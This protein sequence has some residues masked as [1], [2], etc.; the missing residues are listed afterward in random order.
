MKEDILK[1]NCGVHTMKVNGDQ[2]GLPGLRSKTSQWPIKN[3]G[4]GASK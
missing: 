2:S 3:G 4:V 1:N